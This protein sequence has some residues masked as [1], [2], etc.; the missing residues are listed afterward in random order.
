MVTCEMD[1][2]SG[3]L[4]FWATTAL[5]VLA[6]SLLCAVVLLFQGRSAAEEQWV[7]AQ[8]ACAQYHYRAER[9]ACLAQRTYMPLKR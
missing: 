2:R 5:L 1:V 6:C 8:R 4:T 3:W 7:A 9:E